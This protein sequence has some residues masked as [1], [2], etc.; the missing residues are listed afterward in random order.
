[1][2]LELPLTE[3]GVPLGGA[4]AST[5]GGGGEDGVVLRLDKCEIAS[6]F[7]TCRANVLALMAPAPPSLSA[8]PHVAVPPPNAVSSLLTKPIA[9]PA[10]EASL[11]QLLAY[12]QVRMP[13]PPAELTVL[14]DP[15]AAAVPPAPAPS[16][17]LRL[18]VDLEPPRFGSAEAALAALPP[19]EGAALGRLND[20][21]R[22]AVGRILSARDYTL[23]L[24]M[25]GTGKTT[26]VG[27]ATR[28][29]VASGKRVLLCAYTHSALDASESSCAAR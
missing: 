26:L 29:L 13:P 7:A 2:A 9:P 14:A 19:A 5:A 18:V 8:E 20:G 3:V 1:M 17:L 6:V 27:A 12:A 4:A 10:L 15:A 16:R 22:T 23:V 25:P 28:A 24:G 21:Q 11:R